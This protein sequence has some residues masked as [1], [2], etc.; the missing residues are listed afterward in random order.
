MSRIAPLAQVL[1]E[2]T[3]LATPIPQ[4]TLSDSLSEQ[5]AYLLQSAAIQLR[6][7]RG[8]RRIGVKMGFTSRAKM[9]QMGVDD[10]IW[11]RLTDGML[12]D[13]GGRVSLGNFIHPRCEPEIAFLLKKDLPGLV[14]PLEAL[15][16]VEA[17]APAIEIIDSRYQNFKFTL[18]DV[19]AD[20][21]SS[22]GCVVGPWAD[23][24]QELGNLGMVLSFDGRAVQ[25]GSSAAILGSPIRSLVAA[26][27]LSA[28]AGEPLRAGWII[29]AGGATQAEPLLPGVHVRLEVESLGTVEF[30]VDG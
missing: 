13:D 22:A 21:C 3:R 11:G 4:L 10:M 7:S 14:T 27:R 29:M 2:A 26:A 12:V 6:L 1:D 24:S 17:V 25:F 8:E 23:P 28:A 30:S 19:V 18:A 20:N 9:L 15:A 16:A 5:D